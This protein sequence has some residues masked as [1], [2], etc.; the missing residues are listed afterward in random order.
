MG[1]N[2]AIALVCFVVGGVLF[3]LVPPEYQIA[4]IVGVVLL[5]I[6]R[7]K[8]S[9]L[10]FALRLLEALLAKVALPPA[11]LLLWLFDSLPLPKIITPLPGARS[12]AEL[13]KCWSDSWLTAPAR[14]FRSNNN[15][16]E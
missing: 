15:D 9:T 4:I 7:T 2:L 1:N 5:I 10:Q 6:T 13:K 12:R 16:K 11:A 3:Y 14:Y 8:L